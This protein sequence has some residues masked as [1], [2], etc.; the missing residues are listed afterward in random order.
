MMY[1]TP[2]DAWIDLLWNYDKTIFPPKTKAM[3]FGR[4]Q[5]PR[6]LL[7]LQ[8]DILQHG[9]ELIMLKEGALTLSKKR[10]RPGPKT[11]AE[12]EEQAFVKEILK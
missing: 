9:L 7:P 2:H 10:R 4:I 12:V 3:C 5:L 8:Q 6:R 11:N 1:I